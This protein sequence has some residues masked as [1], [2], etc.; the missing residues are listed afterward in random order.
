MMSVAILAGGLATRLRPLTDKIPKALVTVAGKPFLAHQLSYLRTQGVNHVVLCT[1]YRAEQIQ[2]YIGD[3]SDYQLKIEYS[4]DGESPLGTGGA[5]AKALPL[6][7]SDFFVLYGD[8]FLPISFTQV[9]NRY[10]AL[11]KPA[12]MTVFRNDSKLDASNVDFK[13][14]KV[15]EY[16]KKQPRLGM[17]YIDYGLSILSSRIF[18][19]MM[20]H[21]PF[22][23]A[24][25]FNRLSLDGK[26]AGLEVFERFYEIGS[27]DGLAETEAF[28]SQKSI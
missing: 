13:S 11:K 8:S 12:L 24:D 28:L 10:Y 18:S 20:Y 1:G 2:N 14:E 21:N 3:G 17:Q 27:H 25:L 7:G 26:L 5:I 22:D 6:L 16:N 15:T 9:S 23:L 19:D 4:E